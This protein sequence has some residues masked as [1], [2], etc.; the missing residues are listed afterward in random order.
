MIARLSS[1]LFTALL[2]VL[3]SFYAVALQPP[4]SGVVGEPTILPQHAMDLRVEKPDGQTITSFKIEI[5]ATPDERAT[6]L[7]HRQ[8]FGGDQAMLFDFGASRRIAMW[9]KNTPSSLDMIF[10]GPDG[11]IL[12]IAPNTTPFSTAII[13]PEVLS[14]YVLEIGAGEAAKRNIL[15]GDYLR[16]STIPVQIP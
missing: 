12:A 1:F 8:G 5:A 4:I 7:M 2:L 6:G 16:H 3:F 10:A 13:Q 15:E 9:M 11:L 14:H